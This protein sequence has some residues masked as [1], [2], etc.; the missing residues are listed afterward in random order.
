MW[1]VLEPKVFI[2]QLVYL[3]AFVGCVVLLFAG[4]MSFRLYSTRR[5]R[6]AGVSTLSDTPEV[7][8]MLSVLIFAVGICGAAAAVGIVLAFIRVF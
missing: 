6:P 1:T 3:A 7:R 5:S 2:Q 8:K 4:A